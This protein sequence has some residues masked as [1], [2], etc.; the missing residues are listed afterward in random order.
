MGVRL[1]LLLQREDNKKRQ[2]TQWQSRKFLNK[3]NTEPNAT[4]K[5]IEFPGWYL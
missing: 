2:A 4:A 3:K 1:C 5:T